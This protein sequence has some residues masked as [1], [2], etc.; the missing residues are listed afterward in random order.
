MNLLPMVIEQNKLVMCP[1]P[2]TMERISGYVAYGLTIREILDT[3]GI[4][5]YGISARVLVEDLVI[6]EM[7]WDVYRPLPGSLIIIRAVPMGGDGGGKSVTRAVL[8]IA[9][10]AFSMY[11][12]GPYIAGEWLGLAVPSA[13]SYAVSVGMAM[14]G[15]MLLNAL[16]PPSTPKLDER[17][18]LDI[19]RS[20]SLSGASNRINKYGPIPKILGR[21]KIIPPFATEPYTSFKSNDQ[22]LHLLFC[23]GYGP[24]LI[25]DL[26]IGD[27]L[28]TE[29]DDIYYEVRQGYDSD[30]PINITW[31]V[32]EEALSILL[33]YA[34]GYHI[35]TTS[36][37]V[38]EFS[39][40]LV[41]PT[42]MFELD[43][44]GKKYIRNV[45]FEIQYA[46]TGTSDWSVGNSFVN[47]AAQ[48]SDV[49]SV[50]TH[51]NH[52][53]EPTLIASRID[54]VCI[55]TFTGDIK[56]IHGPNGLSKEGLFYVNVPGGRL[57]T[58]KIPGG[59][60]G[61]A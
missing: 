11:V 22:Y 14:V 45:Y 37:D 23:I 18:G 33:K 21:H 24:L 15:S 40:D 49:M 46:P 56:T 36:E 31:T 8:M 29:F 19:T 25:E 55:D 41:C 54:I 3:K 1:H 42:G 61:I 58:P 28:L 47:I 4:T 30:D 5:G 2:F 17:T 57:I 60:A 34:D 53:E 38:D 10:V 20:P 12:G 44:K 32:H 48:E 7:L 50:P 39:V 51:E 26:K 27:T 16:I 43:K 13:G 59:Y 35:R 6:P 52:P 9:V